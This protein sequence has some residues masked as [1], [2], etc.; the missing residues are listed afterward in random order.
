MRV[1][2]NV[3]YA[4]KESAK[5]LGARWDAIKKTWYVIDAVELW[6]FMKW[7][8][9]HLKRPVK[10][11]QPTAQTKTAKRSK[12]VKSKKAYENAMNRLAQKNASLIVGPMTSRTDFSLPDTG[13]SCPP[14]EECEHVLRARVEVSPEQLSHIRSIIN[15]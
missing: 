13:C 2:L 14:W 9:A 12:Q 6:P 4:E 1:D 3:P 7:M 5:R 10:N 8:P 11:T 15:G